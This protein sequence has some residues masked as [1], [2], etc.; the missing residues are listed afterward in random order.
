AAGPPVSVNCKNASIAI[1]QSPSRD[2]TQKSLLRE[3][4]SAPLAQRDRLLLE[5]LCDARDKILE[6]RVTEIAAAALLLLLFR[7]RALV[8]IVEGLYQLFLQLARVLLRP[9]IGVDRLVFEGDILG[10]IAAF[11]GPP[12]EALDR[13]RAELDLPEIT[14]R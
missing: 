5:L 8:E 9:V 4:A 10:R 7:G 2:L 13:H 14:T 1:V 6:L 12:F 11:A 3:P